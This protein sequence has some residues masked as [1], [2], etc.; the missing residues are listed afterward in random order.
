MKQKQF[1]GSNNLQLDGEFDLS[2]ATTALFVNGDIDHKFMC[3]AELATKLCID[4]VFYDTS[5]PSLPNGM[6]KSV[7][8]SCHGVRKARVKL[9]WIAVTK[10]FR[11]TSYSQC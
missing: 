8:V 6:T 4:I 3:V 11:V 10:T 5:R 9:L 7:K 1:P 2:K